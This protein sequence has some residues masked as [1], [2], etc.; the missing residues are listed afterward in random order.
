MGPK[1]YWGYLGT[2]GTHYA[3]RFR[4]IHEMHDEWATGKVKKAVGP[5]N[6][7]NSTEAMKIVKRIKP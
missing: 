3:I 1:Q 6:A 7:I 2:D 5:F 4:A